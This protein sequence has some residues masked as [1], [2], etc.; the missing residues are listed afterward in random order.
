[1]FRHILNR[2]ISLADRKKS[3]ISGVFRRVEFS[4]NIGNKSQTFR[5]M[6]ERVSDFDITFRLRVYARY[7]CQNN[8]KYTLS[9]RRNSNI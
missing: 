6:I 7:S 2:R 3:F 8:L 5:R 4:R 1:M 9:D